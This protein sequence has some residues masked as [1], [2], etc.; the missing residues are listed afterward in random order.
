MRF[1]RAGTCL[2]VTGVYAAFRLAAA[3]I[4]PG[5]TRIG[6]MLLIG[7]ISIALFMF[8]QL[9]VVVSFASIGM[10][11]RNAFMVAAGSLVAIV[12]AVV[13]AR[14][15]IHALL[16]ITAVVTDLA[17][18]FA[19]TSIG[20]MVS[21]II[22]EPGVILPVA[23]CAA[24][25]DFWNVILGPLGQI[26]E[27]HPEIVDKVTVHMPTFIPGL[28]MAM[29]G[30]GDVLFLALF[31]GALWR[32]SMNVKGAFWL[33]FALLTFSIYL[34]MFTPIPA[35]PALVPMGIA[36]IASNWRNFKLKREELMATFYVAVVLL[37]LLVAS[38]QFMHRAQV[39]PTRHPAPAHATQAPGH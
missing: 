27:K 12:I 33:G 29:I 20:Y 21:F 2:A 22:K 3:Y 15:K 1:G 35:L 30:M 34:V 7:V 25:V 19:A 26:V 5:H 31:F 17:L 38:A 36:I 4:R 18:M 6:I 28:P 37:V 24:F 10:R 8:L 11:M 23:I 32:F 9:G 16:P 39:Q 14:L 13:V